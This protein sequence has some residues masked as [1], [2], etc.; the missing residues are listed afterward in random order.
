MNI[1][2]WIIKNYEFV[3]EINTENTNEYVIKM[4]KKSII[5]YIIGE[6]ALAKKQYTAHTFNEVLE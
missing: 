3:H 5:K 1:L 4:S 2:D 6:M